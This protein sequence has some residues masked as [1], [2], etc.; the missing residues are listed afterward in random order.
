MEG[1][2]AEEEEA[3]GFLGRRGRGRRNPH[4]KGRPLPEVSQLLELVV[5]GGGKRVV[6]RDVVDERAIGLEVGV[7]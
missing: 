7:F 3:G 5:V 1:V 4:P 2:D 6:D